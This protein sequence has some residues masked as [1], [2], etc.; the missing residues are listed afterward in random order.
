MNYLGFSIICA[1]YWINVKAFWSTLNHILP[2]QKIQINNIRPSC[3]HEEVYFVRHIILCALWFR[4]HPQ[5]R[6][7]PTSPL[8]HSHNQ[9]H[10]AHLSVVFN[11]VADHCPETSWFSIWMYLF[12]MDNIK[13][14]NPN[15]EIAGYAA[16][17]FGFFSLCI[18]LWPCI[19]LFFIVGTPL[20]PWRVHFLTSLSFRLTDVEQTPEKTNHLQ[21]SITLTGWRYN[22]NVVSSIV[23]ESLM[24]AEYS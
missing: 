14:A 15:F 5:S 13:V 19:C 8:Y 6:P 1:S 12:W 22:K 24:S 17:F 18:T 9:C 10:S 7:G 23:M 11:V 3:R 21:L 2:P 16:S 4:Q 20:S